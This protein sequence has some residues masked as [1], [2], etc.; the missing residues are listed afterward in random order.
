MDA[1]A[2][3]LDEEEDVEAPQ[4]D[5]LDG[6]EVDCEHAVGLLAQE[7]PPRQGG[8]LTGGTDALLPQD[9]PDRRGRQLQSE[10]V[11]LPGDPLIAPARVLAREAEHELAE[12]AADRRSTHPVGVR[13][14]ASNEPAMPAK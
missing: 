12:L 6:E 3:Q 1:A 14:A 11:E 4:R 13:P 10:P 9:L 7:R 8:A 5:R 2:A